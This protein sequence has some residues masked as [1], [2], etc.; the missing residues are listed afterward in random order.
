MA[1]DVK[2]KLRNISNRN[3]L[4]R[5]FN[6][7]RSELLDYARLYFPD[8]IQD[9]SEASLGGLL[10]DMVSY[11]GDNLSFYL[12]HQF[13]ELSWRTAIESQNIQKHLRNSGVKVR[14]AAPSTAKVKFL[15]EI[16]AEE[17]NG[18][19]RPKSSLLPVIGEGSSVSSL[20]GINFYLL[21]D[22]DFTEKDS[23]GR[24]IYESILVSTDNSGKPLSFIVSREG[25]CRSGIET[26]D[27][28]R[29]PDS[30]QAFRELTLENE[31]VTEILEVVDSEGNTYHEV[32]FLSQD[33]VF[34]P[35]ERVRTI[36][37]E[38]DFNLEV[39]PAPYRF[40]STYDFED[41]STTITLGA[42][43][44][45][46][47]DDDLIPDPAS[48]SLPLFGKKK[49][50]RFA[51]DPNS[52]LKTH[53][54]GYAPQ[55]TVL[56]VKYRYGGGLNHNVGAETIRTIGNLI[57]NFKSRPKFSEINLVKASADVTNLEPASGGDRAPRLN[58]LRNEIPTARSAQQRIITKQDLIG[59]IMTLPNKFGR[60]FRVSVRRNFL[61]GRSSSVYIVSRDA[62]G[63]LAKS[64]DTLKLNLV[65]Y[66]N[67]FR[68]V[69]DALDILDARIINIGVEFEVVSSPGANKS[70]VA[71]TAITNVSDLFTQAKLNI[72]LPISIS[73]IQN[74]LL[75]SE[76]V[77]S[78]ISVNVIN[79]YGQIEDRIYSDVPFDV[80]SNT[81]QQIVVG[82]PG[83][84]FE[85]K[86]PLNDIKATV[87]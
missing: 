5:D 58:E 44:A 57:L 4:A 84:I 21:D 69:S 82:P 49:F 67:E 46:S 61:G 33:T 43:D 76:G 59:R 2:K 48:L 1:E 83:T 10:L 53:T 39:A 74:V 27:T 14:G 87:K 42:G 63:H 25:V 9:F 52:M 56:T 79:L 77:M 40:T 55:N 26:E 68:I 24:L 29:I 6:S 65:N 34:I 8:Q 23:L 31:A 70:L 41:R 18:E 66:L 36:R 85:V 20:N 15:F 32:D 38:T 37:D 12:D 60:V 30:Y 3:Y 86:F 16:P 28:F 11:V 73:D 64:P 54:L 62:A 72:D 47:T 7:F 80:K 81:A 35:I 13:N 50:N 17:V 51:I 78:L 71:Q 19:F 45:K 22:L 75:N